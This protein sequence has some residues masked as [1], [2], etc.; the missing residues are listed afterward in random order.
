[1]RL[2]WNSRPNPN[3]KP[4]F[5]LSDTDYE[6]RGPTRYVYPLLY[7]PISD[8]PIEVKVA[9]MKKAIEAGDDVNQLDPINDK[10]MC[11]GRPLNFAVEYS[12]ANFH[13]LKDN[14]PVIKLLLEHGADPRLP[15]LYH[16]RSALLEMR[17][18]SQVE[19]GTKEPEWNMMVPFFKEAYALMDKAAKKL[20]G[21]GMN[22]RLFRMLELMLIISRRA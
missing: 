18:I 9:L 12:R 5:D 2:D 8:L 6:F 17:E 13:F 4:P 1:M 19:I 20:D 16:E 21:K 14:I 15:G 11:F 10:R 3:T 7:V 22:L